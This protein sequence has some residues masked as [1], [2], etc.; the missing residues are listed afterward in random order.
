M[1]AEAAEARVLADQFD[2]TRLIDGI[3]WKRIVNN[4]F[5]TQTLLSALQFLFNNITVQ[6][7]AVFTPTIVATIFPDE[8]GVG[9][10]LRTVP[11]YIA[12][13]ASALALPYLSWK[14]KQRG[15]FLL[16]ASFL[17]M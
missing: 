8:T 2:R 10:N 13:A 1:S 9:Q 5:E 16:F 3:G 7:V 12:G 17:T 6:G 11:P 14:F 15:I 4:I